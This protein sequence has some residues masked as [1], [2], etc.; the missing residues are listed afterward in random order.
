MCCLEGHYWRALGN[1]YSVLT[2]ILETTGQRRSSRESL[3]AVE[4][5]AI[6]VFVP[7]LIVP[8]CE[9]LVVESDAQGLIP[10]NSGTFQLSLHEKTETSSSLLRRDV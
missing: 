3:L 10:K 5:A 6:A 7:T 9:R 1:W 8:I 2:H 4:D